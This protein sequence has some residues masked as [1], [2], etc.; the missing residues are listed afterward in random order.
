M[1]RIISAKAVVAEER[2]A[3]DEFK[4]LS[5]TELATADYALKKAGIPNGILRIDADAKIQVLK[6]V[7]ARL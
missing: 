3:C 2:A 7:H 5:S 1:N 6:L 4:P